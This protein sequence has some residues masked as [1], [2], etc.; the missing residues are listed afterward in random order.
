V[1]LVWLHIKV[2]G[3]LEV[4]AYIT[5][6]AT[7][8][9]LLVLPAW[10]LRPAHPLRRHLV[11]TFTRLLHAMAVPLAVVT[12]AMPQYHI[13]EMM[14]QVARWRVFAGAGWMHALLL[15]VGVRGHDRGWLMKCG[16]WVWSVW[17]G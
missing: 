12:S 16:W 5:S 2:I 6:H 11:C 17:C 10:R 1:Q 14:L 8:L 3:D 4:A 13:M 9:A 15:Q 7:M